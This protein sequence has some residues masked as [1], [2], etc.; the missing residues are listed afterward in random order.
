MRTPII[1]SFFVFF[2]SAIYSEAVSRIEPALLPSP[3]QIVWTHQAIPLDTLNVQIPQTSEHT[4]LRKQL[5]S[6]IKEILNNHHITHSTSATKKFDLR[7]NK[8]ETPEHW[9][10]Q[11]REAY[12]LCIDQRGISIEANHFTGLYYAVQT[13]KQLIIRENN[14]STAAACKIIDYPAFQLRGFM[15]DTARNYLPPA[16][17][18]RQI[19]CMA[20][21]KMNVFHWHLSDHHAWRLESKIYPELHSAESMTRHQGKYYSQSAFLDILHYCQ[22]HSITLIPEL[23]SP[24]HSDA[25]RRALKLPNMKNP[26]AKEAMCNLVDELCKLDKKK[27]MPYIHLGTDE[28]RNAT[29]YV[30]NDYLPALHQVVHKHG[31]TVIGWWHGL[32]FPGAKQVFQTWAQHPPVAGAQHIDSRAN[33]INHLEALDFAPRMFFQQPCRSLHGSETQ[34]GGIL[35]H[36]PDTLITDPAKCF[37]NNPVIPATIAYSE[38]VWS[39]RKDNQLNYWAKLPAKNSSAYDAFA[40]FENRIAEHRDRFFTQIPFPFVKTYHIQW[41]LLGPIDNGAIPSLEKGILK[42][43]YMANGRTYIWGAP[44]HGG[45]IHINHFFDFPSHLPKASQKQIVWAATRLYS[46]V[47]QEIEAWINF[48]TTSSSDNRSG[49][50]PQGHWSANPACKLWLNT[51]LVE[52]PHWK[53]SGKLGTEIPL[54]DQVY[55]SRKPTTLKLNK[56]WNTLVVKTAPHWKWAFSFSPVTKQGINYKEVEGLT[57]STSFP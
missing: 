16:L 15:I 40:D 3:Q 46:P 12:Q 24:G 28:V 45:S 4:A 53:N 1:F 22:A 50:A 8:V 42:N 47:A 19:D 33:Y 23:D 39:G 55:T 10:G 13:L 57:F 27:L 34:L 35:C 41:K 54:V 48:N 18:K 14:K 5:I 37:T 25:F 32:S 52:P 30:S 31:K 29:E 56:G 43:S 36:W 51:Q 21:Y 9:E 20:R 6:E 2:L 26:R 11:H 44:I 49:T 7:L 38:A 17:I